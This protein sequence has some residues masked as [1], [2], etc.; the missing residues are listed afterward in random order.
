MDVLIAESVDAD[1][2]RHD[3]SVE[4]IPDEWAI[5]DIGGETIKLF[6]KK[7]KDAKMVVWNGPM[8]VFEIEPFAMG[9]YFLAQA[10]AEL[11]AVTV[12]GGGET[13]AAVNRAGV[14]DKL[15][16]VSTGGGAFLEFME[17]KELPGVAALEDA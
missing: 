6:K 11:D 14:A 5:V 1:A 12:T 9:T 4:H 7:L 8:G 16:H 17:G 2:A 15:T 10:L 3:M 13:A